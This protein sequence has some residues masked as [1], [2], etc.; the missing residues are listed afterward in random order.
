M[1]WKVELLMDARLSF[2]L[3]ALRPGAKTFEQVCCEHRISRQCGDKWRKRFLREGA[4]GL[5]DRSRRPRGSPHA[6]PAAVQQRV[7][8]LR[9]RYGWGARKIQVLLA[10]EGAWVSIAGANR[11]IARNGLLRERDRQRPATQRFAREACNELLQLDFKG[12]YAVREGKCYPLVLVDDCSRYLHG[13]WPLGG[14]STELVAGSLQLFF[15]EVGVPQAMLLDHGTPWWST[16][17]VHGLTRFS[18]WLLQQGIQLIYAGVGHPQTQGKV[19][20]LNRTLHERTR[21]EGIPETRQQW[22]VWAGVFRQEY[23]QVRPHEALGMRTPAQVYRPDNLRPYVEHPPAWDYGEGVSVRRLNPQGALEYRQ[24][25]LFVCEALAGERVRL[26]EVNDLLL[27]T[28]RTTTVREIDLR[29]G[30]SRAVVLPRDYY[31]HA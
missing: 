29:S 30:R 27:V 8:A 23:N 6:T 3:E 5:A 20:R 19:E 1:P 16:S 22:E 21:H 26:D 4:N 25:R 7:V 15:R 31:S 13:L 2:M 12:D 18:V 9:Q 10:G 11:I 14:Q 17:N 24:R 28:F